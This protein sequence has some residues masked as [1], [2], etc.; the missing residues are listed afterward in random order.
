MSRELQPRAP[1]H[2]EAWRQLTRLWSDDHLPH[3]LLLSGLRGTG[4]KDFAQSL[5]YLVL[6]AEP[7]GDTPCG[8]CHACKLNEAGTHPDLILVEPDKDGAAIKV[9]QIREVVAFG[10][11]TAQQGGFRVVIVCP[12]EAMNAN[13]GNSLLKTLEEPGANTLLLLVSYAPTIVLPTIRSRCQGSALQPPSAQE[14]KQWL[15]ARMDDAPVL[16]LVH[17][18]A[19]R[20][21]LYALSL[22]PLIDDMRKVAQALPGLINGEVEPLG[23]A[24]GWLSLDSDQLLQWLYQWLSLACL[25]GQGRSGDSSTAQRIHAN[26]VALD[27]LNS[28]MALVDEIVDMRRQLRSGGNPNRQLLLETLALRLAAR[29]T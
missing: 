6:C 1:W 27:S 24:S 22:V 15:E 11:V 19:P 20:Q 29:G 16:E 25:V 26:W 14:A 8:V 5:A 13:A 21:P 7:R 3:A 28:L 2:D 12:A 4:L 18:F 23:A 9:N 17:D 10:E